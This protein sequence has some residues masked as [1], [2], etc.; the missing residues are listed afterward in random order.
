V[1]NPAQLSPLD[2]RVSDMSG[3]LSSLPLLGL[4]EELSGGGAPVGDPVTQE[5]VRVLLDRVVDAIVDLSLGR[6]TLTRPVPP[7]PPDADLPVEGGDHLDP[8]ACSALAARC[9]RAAALVGA[10]PDQP[11]A[12]AVAAC[13]SALADG[14]QRLTQDVND[15]R[16]PLPEAR[17]QLRRSLSRAGALLDSATPLQ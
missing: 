4:A 7:R 17:Q 3:N 12:A 13:L 6:V 15:P 1:D 5:R 16:V 2:R 14:L 10:Q 11:L 9:H 8:A